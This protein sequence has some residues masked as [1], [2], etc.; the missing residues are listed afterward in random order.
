MKVLKFVKNGERSIKKKRKKFQIKQGK[1]AKFGQK[2]S[3]FHIRQVSTLSSAN[4]EEKLMVEP[5][6]LSKGQVST[7]GR[8]HNSRFHYTSIFPYFFL[9]QTI[10]KRPNFL[11][12]LLAHLF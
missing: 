1:N 8:V 10:S 2:F 12:G 4:I 5:E 6:N 3:I 7:L 9:S 11:C